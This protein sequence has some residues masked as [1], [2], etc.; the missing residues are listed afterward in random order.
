MVVGDT[1]LSKATSDNSKSVEE[2]KQ[3][4]DDV[5]NSLTLRSPKEVRQQATQVMISL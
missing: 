5:V 1:Q 2:L 4:E 3:S